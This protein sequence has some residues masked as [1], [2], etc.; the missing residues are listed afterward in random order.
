MKKTL[1]ILLTLTMILSLTAC[2]SGGTA[3]DSTEDT[4]T[5][6]T[7]ETAEAEE[8]SNAAAEG[9]ELHIGLLVS[10][11]G[12]G[13][14]FGTNAIDMYLEDIGYEVAGRKI[15]LHE[16]ETGGDAN[17][18]IE[19]LTKL[20]EQ[21][22]CDIVIGPMS[23]AEGTAV[24]EYADV[25]EDEVTVIV[26]SSGSTPITIGAA[27]NVFRVCASACQTT[28]AL[29]DYAYN[30]LGY[31]NILIVSSDYDFTFGQVYGFET[32]F[33]L[34]GGTITDKIWFPTNS[35]D[36]AS[37]LS[38]IAEEGDNYDAI[39]CAIGS[40]DSPLFV[41]QYYE[42]GLSKPLLGGTNFAD[43]DAL[44]SD[45]GEYIVENGVISG[46]YY[47]SDIDSDVNNAFVE[48]F[49][50]YADMLPHCFASDYYTAI[51]FAVKAVEKTGG[52]TEDQTALRDALFEVADG[53]TVKGPYKWDEYHGCVQDIYIVKAVEGE[54]G[55][56]YN[57][58]IKTYGGV[59]QN[60]PI[61]Y[62]YF[63]D[64]KMP[65]KTNPTDEWIANAP[66][67]EDWYD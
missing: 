1:A 5:T 24:S 7:T 36:Y 11:T 54:D 17:T 35:S 19:K 49:A 14:I 9:D 4:G 3:S 51:D 53:E 46:V 16:E 23:G 10:M 45:A 27:D 38:A 29:A 67:V 64:M 58:I 62:D 43:I 18:C 28:Y 41:K 65:D 22:G 61:D 34:L 59:S 12:L 32:Q 8:S 6:E 21:Y 15:V 33:K 55:V 66:T 37:T 13:G 63:N 39:F 50:E 26:A 44:L 48:E 57:E 20:V 2:S 31:R 60:G 56:R 30:E 25:F 40:N 42:Y 52:S 47:T